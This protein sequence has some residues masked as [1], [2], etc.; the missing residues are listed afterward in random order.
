MPRVERGGVYKK[1]TG[2]KCDKISGELVSLPGTVLIPQAGVQE[3]KCVLRA[4]LLTK[5]EW[6]ELGYQ[7]AP[8]GLLKPLRSR[9]HLLS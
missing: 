1:H 8:T 3:S 7:R 4:D 2:K 5:P 9:G 6:A